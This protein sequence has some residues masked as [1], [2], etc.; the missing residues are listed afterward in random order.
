MAKIANI[1]VFVK[2]IGKKNNQGNKNASFIDLENAGIGDASC[3]VVQLEGVETPDEVA[4]L[5][6]GLIGDFGDILYFSTKKAIDLEVVG[7]IGF[8]YQFEGDVGNCGVGIKLNDFMVLIGQRRSA[9]AG[10]PEGGQ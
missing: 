3:F 7:L 9:L 8:L 2:Q 4:Q 5:H 1:L 10:C 6:G